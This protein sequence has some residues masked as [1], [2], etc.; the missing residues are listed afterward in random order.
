M[1]LFGFLNASLCSNYV[2][3]YTILLFVFQFSCFVQLKKWYLK[4]LVINKMVKLKCMKLA[5]KSCIER[6]I[7]LKFII[8]ITVIFWAL[9]TVFFWCSNFFIIYDCYVSIKQKI[10]FK[11]FV[12]RI[13]LLLLILYINIFYIEWFFNQLFYF[14]SIILDLYRLDQ[15]KHQNRSIVE[16]CF[17]EEGKSMDFK[18]ISEKVVKLYEPMQEADSVKGNLFMEYKSVI[19]I[20]FF[21]L[22]YTDIIFIIIWWFTNLYTSFLVQTC[23]FHTTSFDCL[24]QHIF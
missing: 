1:T 17:Y 16:D 9:Y 24:F 19:I 22:M 23:K 4:N 3:V 20:L 14:S 15:G 2:I 5:S 13:E 6:W 10:V 12:L 18:S 11:S 8:S 21:Y 7:Y